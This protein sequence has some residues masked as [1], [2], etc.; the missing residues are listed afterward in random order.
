MVRL[1]KA[2]TT[3]RKAAKDIISGASKSID[4]LDPRQVE[5]MID[6]FLDAKKKGRKIFILGMGRSGLV[7]KAFGL[8]LL[9]LGFNVYV[10]GETI[11][12]AARA[13]DVFVAISGSGVTNLVV[14]EAQL[15]RRIGATVVAV[16]SHPDSPIGRNAHRVVVVKGRTKI[17]RRRDYLLRQIMGEHEPLAPL[18]TM[19]EIS[20]MIFLDSLIVELMDRLK[21]TEEDLRMR[22]ATLE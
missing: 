7:A 2:Q 14:S 1:R 17:A 19:F 20:C 13:G 21:L 16:T 12:P 6:V 18:G 11:N 3:L 15:A 22:H 5:G 9:H 8:R 4:S 10:L